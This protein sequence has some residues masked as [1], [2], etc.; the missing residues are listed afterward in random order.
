MAVCQCEKC[1]ALDTNFQKIE[2][3][4]FG[5]GVKHLCMT[6]CFNRLKTRLISKTNDVIHGFTDSI[7]I[8]NNYLESIT[9][10]TK[11]KIILTYKKHNTEMN[12]DLL[13]YQVKNGKT[14]IIS[15][16]SCINNNSLSDIIDQELEELEQMYQNDIDI[17]MSE[18]I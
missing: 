1:L 2:F 17:Q 7:D 10:Q 15:Q 5:D 13:I 9:F 18:Q 11:T 4:M 12:Y 6:A 14:I 16:Q 8:L 3:T